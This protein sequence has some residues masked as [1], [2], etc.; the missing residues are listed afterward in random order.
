MQTVKKKI[1][2]DVPQYEIVS[3]LLLHSSSYV[4]TFFSGHSMFFPYVRDQIS[5]QYKT[6]IR[7]YHPDILI[8]SE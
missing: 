1:N 5:H 7:I 6:I 2:C 3:I 8:D 4:H